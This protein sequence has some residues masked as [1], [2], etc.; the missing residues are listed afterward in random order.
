[1]TVTTI[2]QLAD[3]ALEQI[4]EGEDEATAVANAVGGLVDEWEDEYMV[5]VEAVA[6]I[7]NAR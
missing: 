6:D 2:R 1:M 3:T 7:I 5:A 4:A